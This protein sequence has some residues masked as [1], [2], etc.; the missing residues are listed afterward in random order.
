M[1]P[2]IQTWQQALP[3]GI[4]LSCRACGE[5]G[6]PVLLFLHG[7]PEGAWVWDPLLLHFSKPENGGYRCVAP[8]LRGYERS[9]APEDV[10]AYRAKYLVQDIVALIDGEC[11]P[12]TGGRPLAALIAH[13]WGGAVAWSVANQHPDRL[14]Q[15][16]IINSPHPGT[17]LRALQQDPAQQAAS[18]YMNFLVQP[19][20]ATQLAAK[21]FERMFGFLT[22]Q[23]TSL[24]S[25]T[26]PTA[27]HPA[28]WLTP[29]VKAQYRKVWQQGL[30]GGLNYYRASPLRPATANDPGASAVQI[31]PEAL[32]IELP[33][34]LLWAQGDVALLP[35][36]TEG[37]DAHIPDLKLVPIEQATHW[38]VHEQPARVIQ[39]IA[40][41]LPPICI[42]PAQ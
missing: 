23:D 40:N 16:V 8:N 29:A 42:K 24:Q 11:G 3:H 14:R 19:E 6:R 31:P 38:V 17:F 28:H 39:E 5:P 34:L 33:T 22:G 26:A 12:L 15:L 41:F 21:D 35:C 32:R 13:D 30:Q 27:D 36:L 18:A 10:K 2:E 1:H 7:F 25:L 4:T 37:L 9:S 20:A